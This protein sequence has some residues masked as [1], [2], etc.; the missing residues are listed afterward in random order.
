[1]DDYQSH[2]AVY[3]SFICKYAV[4]LMIKIIKRIA[5]YVNSK[6]IE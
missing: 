6:D 2:I 5:E 1:M 3:I 4:I